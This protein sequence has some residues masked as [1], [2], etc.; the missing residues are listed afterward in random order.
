[1]RCDADERV[2]CPQEIERKNKI[3]DQ[4]HQA[5]LPSS[6]RDEDGGGDRDLKKG[7]QLRAVGQPFQSVCPERN[8]SKQGAI[9]HQGNEDQARS[10]KQ[11]NHESGLRFVKT[12]SDAKRRNNGGDRHVR[13]DSDQR[14][15]NKGP[16][17][18]L[19]PD[20]AEWPSFDT[21]DP[22]Q[23]QPRRQGKSYCRCA[24]C[25]AN[26]A[27]RQRRQRQRDRQPANSEQTRGS[28]R[29]PHEVRV[30][31]PPPKDNV[32]D[33]NTRLRDPVTL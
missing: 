24:V 17:W 32:T 1:M 14:E 6:P 21:S 2:P 3:I 23:G 7:G 16:S 30:F 18:P 12:G 31:L 8:F 9:R 5:M 22:R 26:S 10:L 27:R 33:P 4:P 25:K 11:P 15:W 19:Q 29:E 28:R 13:R 20:A